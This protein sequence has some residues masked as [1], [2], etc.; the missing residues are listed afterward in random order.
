M[1]KRYNAGRKPD[2]GLR[3]RRASVRV[4][5][6]DGFDRRGA[7]GSKHHTLPLLSVRRSVV[8]PTVSHGVFGLLASRAERCYL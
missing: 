7:L 8:Y 4:G 3:A 2:P 6:H 1:R 5:L